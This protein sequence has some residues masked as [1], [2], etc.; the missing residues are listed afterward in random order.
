M[1][2]E[3]TNVK[4]GDILN[5]PSIKIPEAKVT[6]IYGQSGAGKTTLLRLLNHLISP[7]EGT[8]TFQGT[9]VSTCDPIKLRREVVM[10]GQTPVM[11]PGTIADNLNVGRGFAGLEQASDEDLKGILELVE[12]EK[13]LDASVENLSGGEKQ[14][15]ALGRVMLM[16]PKVVLL[17]EPSSALDED[18]EHLVMER[19]VQW[20]QE[21]QRSVVMVT[22]ARWVVEK[23]GEE[24]IELVRGRQQNGRE[25]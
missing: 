1:L 6:C 18:T 12:L 4:F 13:P 15:I 7:D 8:I 2:F 9:D 21:R 20:A 24:R 16:N 22:H 19:I 5:L 25:S 10:L 3:L 14:R 23:Y 11:F 17:D